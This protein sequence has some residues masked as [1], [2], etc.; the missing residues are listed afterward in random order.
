MQPFENENPDVTFRF[1][2]K[3][4][5]PQAA[6]PQN[7]VQPEPKEVPH[8]EEPAPRQE[9]PIS[10]QPQ[11]PMYGAYQNVGTGRKESPFAGSPFQSP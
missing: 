8:Q 2:E 5:E 10:R 3:N 1:G 9:E 6:V 11:E 7:E 4:E